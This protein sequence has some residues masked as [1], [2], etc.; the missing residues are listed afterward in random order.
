MTDRN[1]NSGPPAKRHLE[2]SLASGRI[3]RP[4]ADIIESFFATTP[5][6]KWPS[7]GLQRRMQ[8]SGDAKSVGPAD[9][10]DTEASDSATRSR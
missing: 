1:R 10:R 4:E 2:E 3:T 8:A 5:S 7:S 9:G 6:P